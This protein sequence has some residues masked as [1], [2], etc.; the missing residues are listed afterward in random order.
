MLATY[1]S[2]VQFIRD[3]IE[4]MYVASGNECSK[5]IYNFWNQVLDYFDAFPIG[6]T[7]TP[8]NRTFGYLNKT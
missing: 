8:N 3:K 4:K 1:Q 7:V 5:N 2:T 6:L